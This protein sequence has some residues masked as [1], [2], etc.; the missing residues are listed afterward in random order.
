MPYQNQLY[1]ALRL[2][3]GMIDRHLTE[4][5]NQLDA[6]THSVELRKLLH[7]VLVQRAIE[8]AEMRFPKSGPLRGTLDRIHPSF[9]AEGG[10]CS[11]SG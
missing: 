10:I 11:M 4:A 2:G 3:S 9:A 5:F 8:L 7:A 6:T 1:E